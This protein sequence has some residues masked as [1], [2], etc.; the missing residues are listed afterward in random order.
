MT[1]IVMTLSALVFTS[2]A[3]AATSNPDYLALGD[4]LAFGYSAQ[5]FNETKN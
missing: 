3:S 1:V 5:L 2:T 4:L